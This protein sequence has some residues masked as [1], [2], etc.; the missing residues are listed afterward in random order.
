M[1][2]LV[3]GVTVVSLL[4][5]DIRWLRVSQREH[6]SPKQA[7]FFAGIWLLSRPANIGAA[8]AIIGLAIYGIRDL[9][10]TGLAM[11]LLCFWPLGLGIRGR[12]GRLA[13]TGRARR[14]AGMLLTLQAC[15]FTLLFLKATWSVG[16]LA[17]LTPILV[18]FAAMSMGPLEGRMSSKFVL[19]AQ[20]KLD[21]ISPRIV[22]ITGSYGKTTTKLYVRHLLEG[23]EGVLASP[24]SYNNL[25]GLCRTIN[26]NLSSGTSILV[27]EMGTYGEGEI[28]E[29]CRTFPPYVAV[30]VSIGEAHLAR[31]KSRATIVR[32]KSEITE[33]SQASV[34]NV[35]VPE[36]AQLAD[37]LE[38]RQMV[39]R[40]SANPASVDANIVVSEAEGRWLIK[41]DGQ[42]VGDTV[43]PGFGHPINL[44]CAWGVALALGVDPSPLQL[45]RSL[46]VP[47]HRAEVHRT[48]GGVQVIDDTYNSNPT[49]AARAVNSAMEELPDGA[50][51]YVVSP[52]MV[53]L[54]EYQDR[55][56]EEFARLV[57]GHPNAM[58]VIVGRTNR[59]ALRSGANGGIDQILFFHTRDE[60]TR[61][62]TS[63]LKA[64]DVILYENDLPDHYP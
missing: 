12:T 26:E 60:A 31:M 22:G 2:W 59:S 62:V 28:R 20:R 35:D 17:L 64:K 13:W 10:A 23:T 63:R 30:I 42:V 52:G 37:S 19:S 18:D 51:L 39:I 58:L 45:Q 41:V 14:L 43:R 3:G 32:A 16:W 46:P 40:C 25:M 21:A 36:L 53:E 27:A 34:L 49:G 54:G 47:P 38:G 55:R 24:G 15:L 8:I 6:Y 1:T 11:I 56:N 29:L 44:A 57:V 5:C 9:R 48:P 33:N 7:C 50:C 4:L 61:A